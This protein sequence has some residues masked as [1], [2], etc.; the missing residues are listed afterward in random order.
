MKNKPSIITRLLS[1]LLVAIMTAGI[2]TA[3]GE[4]KSSGDKATADSASEPAQAASDAADAD[5][6]DLANQPA[7]VFS[8]DVEKVV[9]PKE[10][11]E[12]AQTLKLTSSAEINGT[13]STDDVTLKGSCRNHHADRQRRADL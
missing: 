6:A 13:M 10:G 12:V 8:C 2:L 1:L 3:C 7:A 5:A 11:A 9:A 4:D